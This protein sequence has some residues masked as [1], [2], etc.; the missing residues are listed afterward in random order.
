MPNVFSPR[1]DILPAAQ[2]RLWP[3]LAQTPEAVAATDLHA[4]PG[5][6]AYRAR[7]VTP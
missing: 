1:L 2:Q 4:L 3:E 6:E 5:L 7:A